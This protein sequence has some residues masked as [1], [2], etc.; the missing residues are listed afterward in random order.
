MRQ[1][2]VWQPSLNMV[3]FQSNKFKTNR[4]EW[5]LNPSITI[6]SPISSSYIHIHVFNQTAFVTME[7]FDVWIRDYKRRRAFLFNNMGFQGI[8]DDSSIIIAAAA[9]AATITTT[10]TTNNHWH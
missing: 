8:D 10:T 5:L 4:N 6:I 7:N 9:T 3:L 2:V 1:K